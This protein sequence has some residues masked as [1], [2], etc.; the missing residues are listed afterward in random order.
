MYGLKA[1]PFREVSF[2]A[3]CLSPA[4]FSLEFRADF[5][6]AG[7]NAHSFS[8]FTARLKSCPHTKQESRC[9]AYGSHTG[10]PA[11]LVS[12]EQI[13]LVRDPHAI[14]RGSRGDI[15]G[16]HVAITESQVRWYR[17]ELD[18]PDEFAL[19]CIYGNSAAGDVYVAIRRDPQTI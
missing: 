15:N 13:A 8:A 12:V 2:S 7:A 6:V 4:F 5:A 1:V 11:V 9:R 16:M 3:A 18:H 17:G 19:G 10:S 14:H